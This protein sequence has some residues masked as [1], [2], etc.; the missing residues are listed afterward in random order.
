MMSSQD[1]LASFIDTKLR[2]VEE[3]IEAA[4]AH[5][6]MRARSEQGRGKEEQVTKML[7]ESI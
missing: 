1:T 6:D 4:S 2:E 3:K 5:A 7:A